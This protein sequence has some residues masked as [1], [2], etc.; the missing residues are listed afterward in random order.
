M[1][2]NPF[3]L[4]QGGA[5]AGAKDP[6]CGMTVN[7]EKAAAHLEHG[8]KHYY[9]CCQG[10]ATK[11]QS[12]PEKYLQPVHEPSTQHM[13]G[14]G[15]ISLGAA[16]PVP[17]A[18]VTVIIKDPVCGMS[19]NPSNAAGKYEYQGQT[20]YFCNPKCEDRFKADPEKY[21][22]PKPA[23][24]AAVPKKRRDFHLPHGPGSP[25]GSSRSL[26]EVRH[27]PG[28]G[29]AS[30]A[31]KT[32]GPAR[33]IRRSCATSRD[34]ARYAVW[35]RADVGH[36]GRGQSRAARHDPTLL[37]WPGAHCSAAAAHGAWTD[38]R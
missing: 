27:G 19:V 22:H 20:Y 5:S 6:V 14:G 13:S 34:L 4:L 12:D 36:G 28:T 11:F 38:S 37:D 10:C 33:C 9:F 2:K 29:Y 8:G 7:P 3:P 18:G 30:C 1:D 32:N 31:A 16:K 26:P 15:L 21:L 25:S 23:V 35:P 24:A 17:S